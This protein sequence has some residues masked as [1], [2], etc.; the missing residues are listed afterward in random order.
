[1]EMATG[2]WINWNGRD[3]DGDPDQLVHVRFHDGVDDTHMPATPARN[4]GLAG[5]VSNWRWGCGRR[6]HCHVIAYRPALPA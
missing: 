5:E 2:D 6:N 1:M 3:W 4:L